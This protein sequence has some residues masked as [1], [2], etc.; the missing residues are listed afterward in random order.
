MESSR[1][2]QNKIDRSEAAKL[3]LTKAEL[4][5]HLGL[6]IRMTSF[7]YSFK[8][9][10]HSISAGFSAPPRSIPAECLF[11][12]QSQSSSPSPTALPASTSDLCCDPHT[13]RP[14]QQRS[15]FSY[16]PAIALVQSPLFPATNRPLLSLDSVSTTSRNGSGGG[17]LCAQRH[18]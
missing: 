8:Y 12:S 2:R 14:H 9:A 1:Y 15:D 13:E 17:R 16:S 7:S 3:N 5:N 4:T 11:S 10:G 6:F 18:I